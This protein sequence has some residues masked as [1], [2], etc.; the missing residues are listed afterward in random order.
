MAPVSM[1]MLENVGFPGRWVNFT[2]GT[3]ASTFTGKEYTGD[4]DQQ[5]SNMSSTSVLLILNFIY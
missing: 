2:K 5:V 4:V 1:L 3:T